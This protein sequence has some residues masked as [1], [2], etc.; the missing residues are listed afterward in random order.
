MDLQPQLRLAI[1]QRGENATSKMSK[2]D[3][4]DRLYRTYLREARRLHQQYGHF[5]CCSVQLFQ[6]TQGKI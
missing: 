6:D 1:R 4:V 5:A 2:D 3:L